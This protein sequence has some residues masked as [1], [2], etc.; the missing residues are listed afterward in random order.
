MVECL[1]RY[2]LAG[3]AGGPAAG[4]PPVVVMSVRRPGSRFDQQNVAAWL[5]MGARLARER[6]LGYL[7]C[8]ANGC[9]LPERHAG[10]CVFPPP[11]S[12]RMRPKSCRSTMK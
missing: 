9:V 8:G 7:V 4:L 11:A 3:N 10:Q 6:R 1:G 2:G 5:A 12:R